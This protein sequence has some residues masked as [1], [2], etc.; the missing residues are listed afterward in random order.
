M[1]IDT[2]DPWE[3][4]EEHLRKYLLS[5]LETITVVSTVIG[6]VSG[7]KENLDKVNKLWDYLKQKDI[8]TYRQIRFG[9][10]GNA[11]RLPGGPVGRRISLMFYHISQKLIGFN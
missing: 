7:T 2:V 1:M 6:Y 5:Y 11:M 9:V 8:R 3:A 4:K 10:L